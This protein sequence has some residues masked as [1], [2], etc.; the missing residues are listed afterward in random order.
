M[1]GKFTVLYTARRSMRNIQAYLEYLYVLRVS[2][3]LISRF[4][5]AVL[6]KDALSDASS[7]TQR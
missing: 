3:D 2:P 5:D 1:V 6:E 7:E 4:T